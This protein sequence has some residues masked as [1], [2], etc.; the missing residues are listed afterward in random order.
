M[1]NSIKCKQKMNQQCKEEYIESKPKDI[2]I[3]PLKVVSFNDLAE[4]CG[5]DF[6]KEYKKKAL[7][8][9]KKWSKET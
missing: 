1:D 9:L 2:C 8:L 4:E 7:Q 3:E 5:F 6:S